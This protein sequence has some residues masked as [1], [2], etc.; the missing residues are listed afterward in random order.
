MSKPKYLYKVLAY[1]LWQESL[2]K[3]KLILPEEDNAFIRLHTHEQLARVLLRH[4]AN[5][6]KYMVLTLD[7]DLL[8]G[9]LRIETKGTASTSYYQLHNGSIPLKAILESHTNVRKF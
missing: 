7:P 1:P 3:E 6:P 8:E 5:I 2:G 9:E 4:W